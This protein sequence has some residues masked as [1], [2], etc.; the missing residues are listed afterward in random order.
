MS[1]I[2]ISHSSEDRTLAQELARRLRAQGYDALF[3]DFDLSDGIPAGQRWER[4]LFAALRRSDG[5]IFLGTAASV[6]SHWCFAEVALARSLGMP[7]FALRATD[8]ARLG[9]LGDIQWVDLADGDAAYGRLWA[10]MKRA[11]LDP[12][13]SRPWN[14]TRS[15]YPGLKA[16]SV[17]DAAVFFGRNDETRR[18]I[19]RSSKILLSSSLDPEPPLPAWRTGAVAGVAATRSAGRQRGPGFRS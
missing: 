9:L 10:G 17:E 2:F 4:E 3:L 16:F 14:P 6:T 11:R 5:L 13:E 18:L 19:E 8:S 15:P 1:V 12:S 7:I